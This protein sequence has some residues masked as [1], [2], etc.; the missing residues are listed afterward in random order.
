MHSGKKATRY[1]QKHEK[2]AIA[3]YSAKLKT[4]SPDFSVRQAGLLVSLACPYLAA[5]PDATVSSNAD[6]KGLVEVKSPYT[7]RDQPLA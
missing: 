3:E 6:V 5:S 7:R 2:V 1:G 4:A